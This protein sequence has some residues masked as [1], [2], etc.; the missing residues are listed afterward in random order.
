M[1]KLNWGRNK[2]G[3]IEDSNSSPPKIKLEKGTRF[4]S[5][6]FIA[7]SMLIAAG[8]MKASN[9]YYDIDSAKIIV[10]EVQRV[11]Q[12]GETALEI[13]GTSVFGDGG[14]TNYAQFSETGDLSFLGTADTITGP[15]AGTGGVL[16]MTN[17][18][19]PLTLSTTSSGTLSVTS[20]AA[21]NLSSTTGAWD[22]TTLSLDG[23]DDSNLTVT[24]AGKTLTLEAAGGTTNQVIIN[25][26]GTGA[27]AIDVNA[28]AGGM[29]IDT[30]TGFSIDVTAAT[31]ASNITVTGA[32]Q[33]AEDLTIAV[34]GALGDLIL[35][36]GDDAS[37]TA[38][39]D[40]ALATTDGGIGLTAGGG[41]N[42]DIN[43]SVGDDFSL[44]GVAGSVFGIATS[45]VAQQVDIGTGSAVDTVNIGTGGGADSITIGQLAA[46]VALTDADWS[47]TGAGVANF[48]SL[49][50]TTAG[51]GAFTTLT[52]SGDTTLG[53]GA[54]G[55]HTYSTGAGSTTT[56]GNSTGVMTLA[57]GG[58]TSSWTNTIG[59]LTVSTAGA[60]G[61]LILTSIAAIDMNFASGFAL[62]DGA[63]EYLQIDADG[64]LTLRS[65]TDKKIVLNPGGAAGIVEI[66]AGDKLYV[67]DVPIAAKD[68]ATLVGVIPIFGFDLPTRC[69]TAC[70]SPLWATISREI[71]DSPNFPTLT[72][73]K[74][75]QYKFIIRYADTVTSGSSTWRVYNVTGSTSVSFTVPF[76]ASASLD[77]GE[78]YITDA[79]V[80][81]INDDD[82]KLDVQVASGTIQV[83]SIDLAAYDVVD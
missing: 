10:N 58:G 18:G 79:V 46:D 25:S 9:M 32:D 12:S 42:G 57:S 6:L 59:D 60:S 50:A 61:N 29:E 74:V 53:T 43:L 81:P 2:G 73:G 83:Y 56:L 65:G 70:L 8:V 30:L 1:I 80:I 20:V 55:T 4:V 36:S 3:K 62:G 16:T 77:K 49:G 68:E 37:I 19:G 5:F 64:T 82:W 66:T 11:V 54:S 75:R 27:G 28:T 7:T 47:I 76:S 15:G 44:T 21:L 72:A 78:V 24:G 23:T 67:G 63:I 52:S 41:T 14:A 38:A 48:V 40:L 34:V 39:D 45:N 35:S 22:A 26:A 69:A 51:A 71:E 17:A 13:V 31:T 33:E